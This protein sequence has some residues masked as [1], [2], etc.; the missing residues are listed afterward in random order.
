MC[1]QQNPKVSDTLVERM[2]QTKKQATTERPK[3]SDQEHKEVFLP[4]TCVCVCVSRDRIVTGLLPAI[5]QMNLLEKEKINKSHYLESQFSA[6]CRV[7]VCRDVCV[8]GCVC[9]RMSVPA[10][11]IWRVGTAPHP[12]WMY[13]S[14]TGG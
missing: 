14:V 4:H 11:S 5:N 1:L 6:L 8:S 9:V 3:N 13:F 2:C 10:G 7:C 12:L